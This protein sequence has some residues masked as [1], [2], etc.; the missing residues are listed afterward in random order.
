MR[1]SVGVARTFGHEVVSGAVL[2]LVYNTNNLNAPYI[3][4]QQPALAGLKVLL[5]LQTHGYGWNGN[6]GFQFQPNSRG[7]HRPGVEE[8]N[9]DPHQRHREWIRLGVVRRAGGY[10]EPNFHYQA[11]VLNHL[12]QAFDGGI[13]C[14]S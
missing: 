11:Q 9:D 5:S 6:A 7:P 4:Q 3:F 13:S 12:P 14:E 1:S 10:A 2:G 8:R